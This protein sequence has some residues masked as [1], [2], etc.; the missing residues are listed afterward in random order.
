M[1]A[2]M[3]WDE[4][5]RNAKNKEEFINIIAK[6]LKSNKGRQLINSPFIITVGDKIYEFQ[7]GQDKVN[8]CNHEDTDT[9]II[10]LPI[11]RL[12]ML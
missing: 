11:K 2:G 6:F 1:P 5:L 12:M 10:L 4:F 9:R 7:E 8:K 3:K